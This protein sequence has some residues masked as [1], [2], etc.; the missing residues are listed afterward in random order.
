MSETEPEMVYVRH[1]GLDDGTWVPKSSLW[2]LGASG[3]AE[4]DPPPPPARDAQGNLIAVEEQAAEAE[5]PAPDAVAAD[6]APTTTKGRARGTN[7][8]E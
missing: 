8:E 4:A 5:E 7:T 3:W 2:Q 6:E 1:E